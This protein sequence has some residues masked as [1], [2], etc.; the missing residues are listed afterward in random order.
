VAR[1]TAGWRKALGG[2]REQW[3]YISY[4]PTSAGFAIF[5]DIGELRVLESAVAL[6]IAMQLDS[7]ELRPHDPS[8]HPSR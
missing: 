6:G 4:T 8:G 3:F 5:F 7:G 2:P 1:G